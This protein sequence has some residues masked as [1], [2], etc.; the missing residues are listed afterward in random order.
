L[1]LYATSLTW[2]EVN[3]RCG[4]LKAGLCLE[5][6]RNG[7]IVFKDLTVETFPVPHDAADPVGFL[8]HNGKNRI[9]LATDLG[10]LTPDII[11]RLRGAH[12][13]I[14]EANHDETMLMNG[15]YPR[16]LKKRI[17]SNTG[18]LSNHNAA[19]G[20]VEILS[21]HLSHIILAHLSEK[22]NLPSLALDTVCTRL[23]SAGYR[24][25][26]DLNVYIAD[27]FQPSCMIRF[28]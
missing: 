25:E 27:R 20:L 22:N 11:N 26:K 23:E 13:L 5:M 3:A 18:H 9:A 7:S 17:L 16:V 6:P 2:Q 15:T 14:I 28:D 19:E 1:P 24:P 4:P 8:F 21:P 10:A 12:C